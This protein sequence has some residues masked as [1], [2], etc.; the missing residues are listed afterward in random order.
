V[1]SAVGGGKHYMSNGCWGG[2]NSRV[3][4]PARLSNEHPNDIVATALQ[5]KLINCS[6][7]VTMVT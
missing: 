5:K 2:E 4:E 7:R 3:T 6:E 1:G